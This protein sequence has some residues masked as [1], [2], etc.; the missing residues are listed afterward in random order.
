MKKIG[1]KKGIKRILACIILIFFCYHFWKDGLSQFVPWTR[2]YF[3]EHG[4][5]INFLSEQHCFGRGYFIQELPQSASDV[6]YYWHR[7]FVEKFSAYSMI[8]EENEYEKIRIERL[9]HYQ[10]EELKFE[11]EEII[12]EFQGENYYYIVDSEMYEKYFSFV[13]DVL[14][15]PENK[16][17]YYYIVI[18]K[19]NSANGTCFDGVIMNDITNEVVEFSAEIRPEN[20]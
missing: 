19:I 1:I 13:N 6:R 15:S 17:Q 3:V 4:S 16:E 11:P 14:H 18:S 2:T 7:Q 8:L 12:Y 5:F 20:L 9:E 10:E